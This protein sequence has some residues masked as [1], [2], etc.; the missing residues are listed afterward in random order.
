[1]LQGEQAVAAALHKAANAAAGRTLRL[2]AYISST[3]T[4]AAG[5][6]LSQLPSSHLRHVDLSF[7]KFLGHQGSSNLAFA[8]QRLGGLTSL[9]LQCA[10]VASLL[11]AL[12]S[13]QQLTKLELTIE[14]ANIGQLGVL[15]EQLRSLT[16]SIQAPAASSIS[17][18]QRTQPLHLAHLTA[19]EELISCKSSTRQRLVLQEHDKLPA[20][21][22]RVQLGLCPCEPLLQLRSLQELDLQDSMLASW[23]LHALST[24]LTNLRTV[25]LQ[26]SAKGAAA[27]AAPRWDAMPIKSLV[28][29]AAEALA[30][31]VCFNLGGLGS[32]LT[33]LVLQSDLPANAQQQEDEQQQQQQ[34]EGQG[35]D[36]W[37]PSPQQQQAARRQ[38][39]TA[40]QLADALRELT[41]LEVLDLHGDLVD[42]T[43]SSSSNNSITAQH[44]A[45]YPDAAAAAKERTKLANMRAVLAA[46]VCLP[47]LQGVSLSHM[48]LGRAATGLG[49]FRQQLEALKLA[50]CELTDVEVNYIL[51]QQTSL[52]ALWI[53]DELRITNGIMPVIG[54]GLRQLQKLS[55]YGCSRIG[56]EGLF[57]LQ[58][59]RG[60][61]HFEAG[62]T[63]LDAEDALWLEERIGGGLYVDIE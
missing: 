5:A 10:P 45:M 48:P 47:Q 28:I 36:N 7:P 56:S 38:Q 6:V 4:P 25:S 34:G 22:L 44:A 35:Q 24:T 46:V 61:V 53:N 50:A 18:H 30:P 20:A 14:A 49:A 2:Q 12:G 13:L 21:L 54:H 57:C 39:A 15:P 58:N 29:E 26:Y 59:M 62:E 51:L 23:E 3:A 42:W 19:L 17:Q 60:L 52:K 1:M 41:A 31:A 32:S 16:L 55:L 63:G 37:Q 27:A 33:R 11:P 8:L 9:A 40:V 43:A